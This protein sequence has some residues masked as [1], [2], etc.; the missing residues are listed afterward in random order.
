MESI[1]P[2]RGRKR[3]P[4]AALW[5]A[6][7]VAQSESRTQSRP[8]AGDRFQSFIGDG[9][10]GSANRE[11]PAVVRLCVLFRLATFWQSTPLSG[12]HTS[13]TLVNIYIHPRRVLPSLTSHFL[14]FLVPPSRRRQVG[15]GVSTTEVAFTSDCGLCWGACP[16]SSWHLLHLALLQFQL[17]WAWLPWLPSACPIKKQDTQPA[18]SRQPKSPVCY[19]AAPN[20]RRQAIRST[21]R[22]AARLRRSAD[23]RRVA[24][25]QGAAE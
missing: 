21:G 3:F 13:G 23:P 19:Y 22:H 7:R 24:P 10:L 12:E 6:F 4:S 2:C 5:V 18:Q 1:R 17:I 14:P 25:L 9:R 20:R 11:S 8:T 16:R 15:L